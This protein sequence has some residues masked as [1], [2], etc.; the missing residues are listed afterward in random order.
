MA[1]RPNHARIP[2]RGRLGFAGKLPA[3]CSSLDQ[4]TCAFKGAGSFPANPYDVVVTQSWS[5]TWTLG[6]YGGVLDDLRTE[7]RIDA[8]PVGQIQA[9]VVG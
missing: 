5:A 8:F 6:G 7:G 1:R 2:G 3:R 9:V 4:R